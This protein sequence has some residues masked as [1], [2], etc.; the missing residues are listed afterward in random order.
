MVDE[1]RTHVPSGDTPQ[2]LEA[3]IAHYA[4]DHQ[5]PAT[6][7]LKRATTPPFY[8]PN[9][10]VVLIAGAGASGIVQTPATIEC[11]FPSQAVTGFNYNG[12]AITAQTPNLVIPRPDL[13]GIHGAPWSGGARHVA[14]SPSSSSSIL[15]TPRQS[16]PPFKVTMESRIASAM[17]TP[18]N[19]IGVYPTSTAVQAWTGESRGIRCNCWMADVVSDRLRHQLVAELG[20]TTKGSTRNTAPAGAAGSLGLQGLIQLTPAAAFN[21]EARLKAFLA[22]NPHLNPAEKEAFENLLTFVRTHDAWICCRRDSMGFNEQL[23]LGARR[24]PRS[25]DDALHHE[26]AAQHAARRREEVIRRRSA[27]F[28]SRGQSLRR[29]SSALARRPVRPPTAGRRRWGQALWPIN[30]LNSRYET[31]FTPDDLAPV[32]TSRGASPDV[33]S[34]PAYRRLTAALVAAGSAAAS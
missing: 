30:A 29:V 25:E 7:L 31:I 5:L 4:A 14:W 21:M 6:R 32:L 24:V 28:P 20:S 8:Q 2:A 11:R 22:N 26:P 1:D 13:T 9:N 17:R 15:T 10:P 34:G 23:R 16:P 3:A 19:D 12:A 33:A 27:T 18:A